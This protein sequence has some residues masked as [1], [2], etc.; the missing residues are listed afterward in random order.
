[1]RRELAGFVDSARRRGVAT[2]L[3]LLASELGFDLRHGTRTHPVLEGAQLGTLP[4]RLRGRHLVYH[5]INPL[6]MART[7]AVL[8]L[9]DGGA[10][11]TGSF[12][13]F[14][15]GS[16]RA[17]ILAARHGL[18]AVIG[19]ECSAALA[20]ACERN[21]ATS[22]RRLGLQASRE[23]RC[24]D[25]A[26]FVVP[27]DSTLWLWF[28]PF[29]AHDARLVGARLLESLRRRPRV[30]YLA[31]AHPEQI[32][33]LLEL[34]FVAVAEVRVAPGHQDAVILRAGERAC[35]PTSLPR[36]RA[37]SYPGACG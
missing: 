16:G 26:E 28:N 30:A 24:V 8:R 11:L 25:A 13:D 22:W 33:V 4:E 7:L 36:T 2:T 21:L 27:D 3:R 34:G 31:Y 12:V 17:L 14:G 18:R 20:A 6:V 35:A 9:L 19:V 32:G 23:L 5:P 29:D 1:M 10:A 15:C 37:P